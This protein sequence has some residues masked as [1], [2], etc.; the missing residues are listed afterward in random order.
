MDQLRHLL[1]NPPP[2]SLP[3]DPART[4]VDPLDSDSSAPNTPDSIRSMRSDASGGLFSPTQKYIAS[5]IKHSPERGHPNICKLLDFFEDREFYYCL[6]I[7]LTLECD[8]DD[9]SGDATIW[10]RSGSI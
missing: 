8:A 1:Y 9:S 4:R 7:H 3:W 10:N 5:E 2:K 6:C